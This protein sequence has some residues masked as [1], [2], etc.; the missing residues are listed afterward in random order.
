MPLHLAELKKHT[1]Q[2]DRIIALLEKLASQGIEIEQPIVNKEIKPRG[3]RK[4]S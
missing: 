1:E 3:R 4:I 2:N